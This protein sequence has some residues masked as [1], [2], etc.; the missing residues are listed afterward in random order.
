MNKSTVILRGMG[1]ISQ[2]KHWCKDSSAK[3]SSGIP[4]LPES[5]DAYSFCMVGCLQ[6]AT[7]DE[8]IKHLYETNALDTVSKAANLFRGGSLLS[9]STV[10]DSTRTTHEDVMTIMTLAAFIALSEE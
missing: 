4:T 9:V 2:P 6:R 1:Y 10:N 3:D 7:K 8:G 5:R